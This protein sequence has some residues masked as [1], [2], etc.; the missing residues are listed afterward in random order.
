MTNIRILW[1][2]KW[3]NF[4][5]FLT[6]FLLV[7]YLGTS[8]FISQLLGE[9][10]SNY[11]L[12]FAQSISPEKVATEVYQQIPDLPLENNYTSITNSQ[13]AIENTL[14]SRM[15]RYHQYIKAR[16]T[17]F[18]LDWKLTLADYL[19]KNEIIDEQRY[20]GNSTL[21]QN[22]FELDRAII[23]KLTMQQRDKLVNV[24]V[25]IY[26]PTEE[27]TPEDKPSKNPENNNS[28]PV[29]VLP[30]RGGADLLSP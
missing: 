11:L 10:D 25:S 5:L 29:F 23:Q 1:Q 12:V 13:Q 16:P 17:T 30:T 27:T 28:P 3:L 24:L 7:N 15:V 18:R 21:T 22:P 26:N 20:P 2:E 14:V 4:S 6:A 8:P 9:K 19:G